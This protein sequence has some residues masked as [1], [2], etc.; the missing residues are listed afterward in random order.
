MFESILNVGADVRG[1][2]R[3]LILA[4]GLSA[5][6]VGCSNADAPQA[7]TT[8]PVSGKVTLGD[9][10][11]LT[12][13]VVVFTAPEK[14]MQFSSPVGEDGSFILKSSY[15]DGA[16]EGT[17]Q[18]RIER[19]PSKADAHLRGKKSAPAAPYPAKY[20]DESTSGLTAVVKPS[21][22]VLEPFVLSK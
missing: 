6:S 21:P 20:G 4:A 14:G 16:P 7:M 8:Y 17:Y 19:D 18:V 11:P 9:G 22:N 15:G 12:S 10:K 2:V 1:L 3:T 13:G 5:G